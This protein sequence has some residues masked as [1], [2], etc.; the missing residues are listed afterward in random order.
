MPRT[1]AAKP[2]KKPD[3]PLPT[4][5]A[6]ED[7]VTIFGVSERTPSTWRQRGLLPPPLR[8]LYGDRMPVWLWA[9]I[10]RWAEE[11]GRPI[12]QRPKPPQRG[13]LPHQ[14]F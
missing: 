11:R 2:R 8:N 3:P 10:E 14:P 4:L 7:L 6:L 5:V 12:V 9:D 13:R 1:P